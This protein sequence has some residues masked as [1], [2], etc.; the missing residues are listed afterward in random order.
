MLFELTGET[1]AFA[2][3]FPQN[4]YGNATLYV[5]RKSLVI[6]RSHKHSVRERQKEAAIG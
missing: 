1:F 5:W 6:A 2:V 4:I 3:L